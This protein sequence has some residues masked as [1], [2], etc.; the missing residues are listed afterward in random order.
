MATTIQ[1]KSETREM[2]RAIGGKGETYDEI[3]R[4]L[5]SVYEARLAEI[6]RRFEEPKGKYVS[7]E[8][9]KKKWGIK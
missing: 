1:I 3:I 8:A 9:L 7:H 2:L 4:E 5:L 6:E